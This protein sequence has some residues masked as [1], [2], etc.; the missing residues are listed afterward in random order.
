MKPKRHICI[1][2]LRKTVDAT[3]A[4]PYRLSA[5]KL[6]RGSII[7]ARE[8]KVDFFLIPLILQERP[9]IYSAAD[10]LCNK[11]CISNRMLIPDRP[12]IT[13]VSV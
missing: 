3:P 7:C 9:P 8:S 12:T 10:L 13:Q 1:C 4:S 6:I 2:T 11:G 5:T